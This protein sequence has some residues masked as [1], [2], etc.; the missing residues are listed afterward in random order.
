MT[1]STESKGIQLTRSLKSRHIFMLSLGGVIGTGLFMGSGVTIN[2]G[3]P[4][5]A[6][7]S[8]LVAGFL[9]YLVMV[10]LGELSVQMPVS[11]SFQAHATKYIG[12]ATGFM[13][14]WVYWMSW[15]TTVGLEFTAAGMLMQRWFPGVPIWY[16]SA[17]FVA[18]LFGINALATRAF[19]EAEYWFAGVK[20]LAILSFIVVGAL[21]I[22]GVIDLPSGAPAPM[23]D[24]LKGDSLFPNGL[25][26]VFA[27]MMTVVYA[28]QGCEIMGVA[29]GETDQPEKS[30]PRAVRNVVFRVLI[31]YVLAVMVLAAIIPWQQ[32]G[33]VESPFV[34]VFDMVGIPYAA[35]LMN[36]VILTAILSVGNS[37]LY[38][39]TRILWAMSKSGMAPKALSPLSKQ[40]VPLRALFITL[41]FAL[42]SL[43]TS[44][45]AA[46]TLFMVLMA[47][48]GMAGTVTWIVIALAQY[49]FRRQFL[50][51]GG[52]LEQLKYRAPWFPLVPLLCI[53]L[54]SSLFVFLA[55]DETQRPSLYW[56]SGFIALCYG[57]YYLMQR[58]RQLQPAAAV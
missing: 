55:L 7:L 26:A 38:A 4:W 1:T 41:C 43:M 53:V 48:S 6:I 9:M 21:V 2:Q 39:S 57:A 3:G 34:Q 58:K 52:Q 30:I 44:F 23:F 35:D 33:L 54:C 5:G 47:V 46:D 14:G 56:G 49:R 11:G 50:R 31:F 16:W 42:I 10:C 18:L 37:G 15:A 20:V 40:G 24:N 36:F 13:I 25:P 19:G 45:I 28:F 22:F 32:A 8:Y 17:L 51:E 27:V 29:A 12:P